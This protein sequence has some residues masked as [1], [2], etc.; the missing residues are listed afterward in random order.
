MLTSSGGYL[1]VLRDGVAAQQQ[2]LQQS[3]AVLETQQA[4]A[5]QRENALQAQLADLSHLWSLSAAEAELMVEP[6]RRIGH[7]SLRTSRQ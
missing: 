5:V 2:S 3:Q 4:S 7:S 6:E 1:T